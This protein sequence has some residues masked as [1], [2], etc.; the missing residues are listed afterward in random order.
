MAHME[1][2]RWEKVLGKFKKD[3]LPVMA[4]EQ[5][6]LTL[7]PKAKTKR[8][9][10]SLIVEADLTPSDLLKVELMR[11]SLFHCHKEM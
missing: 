6:G 1:K 8:E 10:V 3:E 5:L 2:S 11:K 4:A 7:S 9:M